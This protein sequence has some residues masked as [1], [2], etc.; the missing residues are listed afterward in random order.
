MNLTTLVETNDVVKSTTNNSTTRTVSIRTALSV[1]ETEVGSAHSYCKFGN[2]RERFIIANSVQRRIYHVKKSRLRHDLP[3]SVNDISQV[4][5]FHET[6]HLRS[7]SK[8]KSSRTFS[9]LQY[10]RLP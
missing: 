5:Y 4:Y 8:I 7:F 9:N 3:A 6:S 10:K 1:Q 2:V